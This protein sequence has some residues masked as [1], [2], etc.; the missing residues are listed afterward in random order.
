MIKAAAVKLVVVYGSGSPWCQFW[1]V[2][3]GMGM[4]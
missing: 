3:V 1:V 2:G 4:V